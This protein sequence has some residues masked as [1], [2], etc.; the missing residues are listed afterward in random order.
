MNLTVN[1]G[2]IGLFSICSALLPSLVAAQ[3]VNA[4]PS[5]S[6]D[7]MHVLFDSDRTGGGDIYVMDADGSNVRRLTSDDA[8]EMGAQWWEGGSSLVFSRYEG[9]PNPTWYETDLTGSEPTP[10]SDPRRIHWAWSADG[11]LLLTGPRT[12]DEPPHIWVE[13][14]DG[15]GRRPLTRFRPGSFNS[16]MSFSPDGQRVLFESFIGSVST[17]QVY[18]VDTAGGEARRLALGTDPKWSPTGSHIAFKYHDPN[19]D[20]YWLH[21]MES[22][23]TND[24]VMAEGTMPSW[25]PDGRRL[26]FMARVGNG[27]QIHVVDIHS[28]DIVA[29]TN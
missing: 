8:M 20:R 6:P 16:D 25:F 26:A 14:A 17:G 15:S 28:G 23:G 29:L 12:E 19:T 2:R 3:S 24:R 13:N 11:T 10:L 7:G 5:V 27:W 18:V 21:V 4:H 1:Y 9:G 22:D